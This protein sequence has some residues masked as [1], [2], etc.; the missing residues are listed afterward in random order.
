MLRK[1][2]KGWFVAVVLISILSASA[3]AFAAG[4][5][6]GD[7]GWFARLLGW[8]GLPPS[9]TPVWD[10]SSANI[11]PDG[12]PG[13]KTDDSIHIDPNGQPRSAATDDSA[14]IDPD[15]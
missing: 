12:Q 3:P 7:T 6:R 14:H 10:L 11:D 5:A 9:V 15:G 2:R 1:Q 13:A 4:P 8:L